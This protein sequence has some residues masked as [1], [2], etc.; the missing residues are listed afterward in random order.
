[1][2]YIKLEEVENKVRSLIKNGTS[3]L[4]K[5]MQNMTIDEEDDFIRGFITSNFTIYDIKYE[6]RTIPRMA[7]RW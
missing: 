4:K 2:Q 6:N 5:H 1:M 3:H 7:R